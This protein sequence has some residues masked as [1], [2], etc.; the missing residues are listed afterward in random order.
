LNWLITG[1]SGTGAAGHGTAGEQ[2]QATAVFQHCFTIKEVR[3]DIGG[4]F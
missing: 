1:K 2:A 4:K 3:A